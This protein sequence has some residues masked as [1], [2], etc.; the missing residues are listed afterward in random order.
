M[1]D[2]YITPKSAPSS[3]NKAAS[4]VSQRMSKNAGSNSAIKSGKGHFAAA[5]QRI[6]QKRSGVLQYGVPKHAPTG[7]KPIGGSGMSKPQGNFGT[8]QSSEG[9]TALDPKQQGPSSKNMQR[10]G[11]DGGI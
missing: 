6:A 5:A 10:D 11:R 9:Q 2:F 1:S 7:A 4:G 3:A 8:A